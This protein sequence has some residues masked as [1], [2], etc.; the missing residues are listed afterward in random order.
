MAH[1]DD[2]F[3]ENFQRQGDDDVRE[4]REANALAQIVVL[5]LVMSAMAVLLTVFGAK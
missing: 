4:A 2:A 1:L 5:A 3:R